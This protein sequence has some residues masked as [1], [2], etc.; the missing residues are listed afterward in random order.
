MICINFGERLWTCAGHVLDAQAGILPIRAGT[1]ESET[2][3]RPQR[4][5]RANLKA[6]EIAALE[7]VQDIVDGELSAGDPLPQE[8]ELLAQYGVSR[9]SLR[10]A[11]RLLQFLGLIRVRPGPGAGT[12]VGA[13][14]AD[15]LART[16]VLYLHLL[17]CTYAEILDVFSDTQAIIGEKAAANPD[18]TLV[19]R[20][21]TPFLRPLEELSE[22]EKSQAE[23]QVFHDRMYQLAGNSMLSLMARAVVMVA[24]DH[25]LPSVP[26]LVPDIMI[27]DHRR[28][29]LAVI[30]GDRLEAGRLMREHVDNIVERFREHWPAKIGERPD[31]N[32]FKG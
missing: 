30:A 13:A 18:R 21:M 19:E 15:H 27:N 1:D 2:V 20:L 17:G 10:E 3:H 6:S 28:I 4:K 5:R 9:P 22:E 14:E 31:W 24:I 29:A 8:S 25:V 16:M 12:V 11:L 26:P 23:G 7:L 32:M